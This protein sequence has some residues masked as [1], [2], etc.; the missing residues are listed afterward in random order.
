MELEIVKDFKNT[1]QERREVEFLVKHPSAATPARHEVREAISAKY[2]VS[3]DHT[4]VMGM[5]TETGTHTSLGLCY[6]YDD[7]SKAKKLVP[8]HVQSKNI[9]AHERTKAKEKK[10]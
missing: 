5:V 7:V 6:V 8:T 10:A 1:L 4:Y 9:P 3:L 2:G